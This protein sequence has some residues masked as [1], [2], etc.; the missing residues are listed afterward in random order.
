MGNVRFHLFRT[1]SQISGL[2]FVY[3]LL[4]II[5]FLDLIL[6]ELF[7]V[8]IGAITIDVYRSCFEK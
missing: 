7:P 8:G 1:N 5:L 6:F 2:H 4:S 3:V